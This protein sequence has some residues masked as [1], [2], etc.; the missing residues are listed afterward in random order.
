MTPKGPPRVILVGLLCKSKKFIYT[1]IYAYV[2]NRGLSSLL[3][4][5]CESERSLMGKEIED[6][7]PAEEIYVATDGLR[8]KAEKFDKIPYSGRIWGISKLMI[9]ACTEKMKG[10]TVQRKTHL[11]ARGYE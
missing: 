11:C 9:H 7:Q 3:W 2:P 1:V 10:D 6:Q 5:V 8:L 4:Y